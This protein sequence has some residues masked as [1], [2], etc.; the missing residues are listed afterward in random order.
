MM[1]FNKGDRV[2]Y[3][4]NEGAI[5]RETKPTP[6]GNRMWVVDWDNGKRTV[7]WGSDLVKAGSS[8]GGYM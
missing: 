5:V 3:D 2:A 7:E 1:D 8:G 4:D 6:N